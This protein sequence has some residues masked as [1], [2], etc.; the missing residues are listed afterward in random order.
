M[1][2]VIIPDEESPLLADLTKAVTFS[3]QL[4][5][6][7]TVPLVA[8][9]VLEKGVGAASYQMIRVFCTGGP[10]FFMFHIRTKAYYYDI[11]ITLGGAKYMPTG[12]G[13]VLGHTNFV[14]LFRMFCNSHFNYGF[15]LF[16]NLIV[17]LQF[18]VDSSQYFAVSWATWLFALDLLYAPFIFNCLALDRTEVEKDL[19]SWQ[20]FIRRNDMVDPTLSWRAHWEDN[21]SI[22]NNLGRW[23]RINL[24]C[25]NFFW[26]ILALSILVENLG[27]SVEHLYVVPLICL[28][29]VTLMLLVTRNSVSCLGF[30]CFRQ[31]LK[32]RRVRRVLV[33][34]SCCITGASIYVLFERYSRPFDLLIEYFAAAGYLFAFAVNT[35]FYLGFRNEFIYSSYWAWDFVLGYL[36]LAPF[37]VLSYM[38]A[39]SDAHMRLLYNMKFVTGLKMQTLMEKTNMTRRLAELENRLKETETGI[40]TFQSGQ[41]EMRRSFAA[42]GGGESHGLLFACHS[43][44]QKLATPH[45]ATCHLLL[46]K[47]HLCHLVATNNLML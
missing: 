1:I 21:N 34:A 19:E 39:C 24:I 25:R 42:D 14:K 47:N 41:D 27:S 5:I 11:T 18:I 40:R 15:T 16:L 2:S 32:S 26:L 3:V 37:Y 28:A 36:L 10:L 29:G 31:G 22:Y 6:I 33:L 8:E 9:L 30:G 7:L 45:S 38:G 20:K 43:A 46:F 23:Q 13:F 35:M 12:R 17:Y 4:G 44:F